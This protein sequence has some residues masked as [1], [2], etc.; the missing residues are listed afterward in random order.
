MTQSINPVIKMIS[1]SIDTSSA[2]LSFMVLITCGSIEAA[3]HI[4]AAN[5]IICVN[6]MRFGLQIFSHRINL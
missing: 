1:I 4:P 5:P 3:V 6:S 2:F